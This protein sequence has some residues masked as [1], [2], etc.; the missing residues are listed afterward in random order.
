METS[1]SIFNQ[2]CV[3]NKKAFAEANMFK[4][5]YITCTDLVMLN[6]NKNFAGSKN[7]KK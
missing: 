3:F 4:D 6:N 2:N 1:V 7:D 5:K